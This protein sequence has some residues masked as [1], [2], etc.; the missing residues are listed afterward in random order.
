M[1]E[2]QIAALADTAVRLGHLY[3]CFRGALAELDPTEQARDYTGRPLRADVDA[4]ALAGLLIGDA[5]GSEVMH[6]AYARRME[7]MERLADEGVSWP[8]TEAV[9]N[10]MVDQL[11]LKQE[12]R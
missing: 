2:K 6:E 12:I 5:V 3:L 7:H 8:V 9:L 11:V 1:T 4:V 10:A